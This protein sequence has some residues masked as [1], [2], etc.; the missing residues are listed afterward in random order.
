MTRHVTRLFSLSPAFTTSRKLQK[1]KA[2]YE[3]EGDEEHSIV[4]GS[5]ERNRVD[6]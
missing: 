5:K 6:K 4:Q 2:P 3:M 1:T